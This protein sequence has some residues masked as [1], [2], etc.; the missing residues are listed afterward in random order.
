MKSYDKF[1]LLFHETIGTGFFTGY[2][3]IAP[4]TFGS[5]TA[6]CLIWISTHFFV[7]PIWQV[8]LVGAF[9]CFILGLYSSNYLL[10]TSQEKDPSYIVIDEFAGMFLSYALVPLTLTN[11]FLGFIF[12]RFFDI[13]KPWPIRRLEFFQRGWGIMLDDILAGVYAGIVLF[14]V[15]YF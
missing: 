7:L 10:Q 14:L 5:W 6:A 3:S 8:S 9:I 13:L 15:Q 12:F 2:L 4:G 11:F 1:W